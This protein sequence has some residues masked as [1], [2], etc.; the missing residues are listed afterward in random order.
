MKRSM[1][2]LSGVLCLLFA[3]CQTAQD[4]AAD[5]ALPDGTVSAAASLDDMETGEL[6]SDVTPMASL[7]ITCFLS[8]YCFRR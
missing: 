4:E 8:E 6:P 2:I 1:C 5:A 7:Q 3:S